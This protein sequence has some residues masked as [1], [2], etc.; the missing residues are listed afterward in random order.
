[1]R[2]KS[3]FFVGQ[4]ASPFPELLHHET[5]IGHVFFGTPLRKL[6]AVPVKKVISLDDPVRLKWPFFY[7]FSG[8]YFRLLQKGLVKYSIDPLQHTVHLS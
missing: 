5:L 8:V 3:V 2:C 4:V 1:M 6:T 7:W